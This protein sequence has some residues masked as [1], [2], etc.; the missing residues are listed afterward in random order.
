MSA[1]PPFH[2]FEALRRDLERTFERGTSM[3]P[4]RFR[5][6]F[7]PG[8]MGRNYPL[9]NLSDD[10]ENFYVEALAPGV[11]PD[12]FN[13][14]VVKNTLTI[15][16]D[17]PGLSDVVPDRVHRSERWS[18][19][20]ARSVELPAEIDADKVGADY[21]NGVLLLTLPRSESARPRRVRIQAN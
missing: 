10:S 4:G 6:S 21:R 14:S 19:Q 17:K 11:N 5:H 1:F 12:D 3:L 8:R 16:G 13:V 7:L 20:F 15:T 9:V 2:D 18:G